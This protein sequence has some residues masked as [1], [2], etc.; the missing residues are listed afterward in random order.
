[1]GDPTKQNL[2]IKNLCIYSYMFKLQSSSKYSLSI[3]CNRLSRRCFHCSKQ[4]LNSL[5]LMPFSASADFCFTSSTLAKHF[6]LGTFFIQGNKK[7]SPGWNWVNRENG[8]R[9][10][11]VFC[12]KLLN[13]QCA[14]G[15]FAPKSPIMKWAHALNSLQK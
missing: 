8:A 4:F 9:G 5:I 10:D 1:M 12:Q 6:P 2:F 14:M 13:T 15:R 11:A 7:E 3:W